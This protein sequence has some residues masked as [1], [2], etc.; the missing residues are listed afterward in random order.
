MKSDRSNHTVQENSW[1][2][3]FKAIRYL[4]ASAFVAVLDINWLDR[5]NVISKATHHLSHEEREQEFLTELQRFQDVCDLVNKVV[6]LREE[7]KLG[8]HLKIGSIVTFKISSLESLLLTLLRQYP[9]NPSVSKIYFDVCEHLKSFSHELNERKKLKNKSSEGKLDKIDKSQLAKLEALDINGLKKL[10]MHAA[11]IIDG[12]EFA[13]M[14]G[15][16]FYTPQEIGRHLGLN[17]KHQAQLLGVVQPV[18]PEVLIGNNVKAQEDKLFNV[19][20]LEAAIVKRRKESISRASMDDTA[21][22][23]KNAKPNKS[24]EL[25]LKS[26][27]LTVKKG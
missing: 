24:A 1:K 19:S 14:Q 4:Q 2:Q 12:C 18:L 11:P 8:G 7:C 3:Q 27:S 22:L 17:D 15:T 25:R 21:R 6:K 23:F 9:Q 10:Q 5:I 20:D 16:V 26:K 13:L